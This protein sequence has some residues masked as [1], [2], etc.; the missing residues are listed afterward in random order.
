MSFVEIDLNRIRMLAIDPETFITETASA[1]GISASSVRKH[2]LR[3]GLLRDN[4]A[5]PDPAGDPERAPF[6]LSEPHFRVL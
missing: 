4:V 2:L 5:H 1:L 3:A 6:R